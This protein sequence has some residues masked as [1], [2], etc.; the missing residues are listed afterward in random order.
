MK[1]LLKVPS[2]LKEKA[3]KNDGSLY[4]RVQRTKTVIN[5]IPAVFQ[6]YKNLNKYRNILYTT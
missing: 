5:S 2:S 4:G 1:L 6:M 3:V